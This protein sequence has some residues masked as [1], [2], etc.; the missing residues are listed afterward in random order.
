MYQ[1]HGNSHLGNSTSADRRTHAKPPQISR[2]EVKQDIS[3]EEWYSFEEEWKRFKRITDL[4]TS[5]I[6]DQL[7][8]CCERPL[9]R[10]ILKENPKI[11]DEGEDALL[12]AIQKM[13]VLQVA[14]SVRRTKLL[15][16]KQEL[17]QIFREFY[18]NARAAASTC[19]FKISCPKACCADE[20]PIDYTSKV[21]K[22]ILIAGIADPEIRKDVLGH[23]D[24]D[25][26]ADKDI[27]R[28]VEEKE[29]AK[30][31]V[32]STERSDLNAMS[33]YRKNN[34]DNKNNDNKNNDN[35]NNDVKKKL[36]MKGKCGKC[37][38]EMNLYIQ[39]KSSGKFNKEPFKH[40]MKCHKAEQN[41]ENSSINFIDSMSSFDRD[42]ADT[43]PW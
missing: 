30:N 37:S 29:M 9:S 38:E 34:R 40:C 24:L 42:R 22:D 36:G 35:R 33:T 25:K 17:G 12:E 15:A 27:V 32:S 5:E 19:D 23:P 26:L 2:P 31:A 18:A 11:T 43:N 20:L 39:F 10:L 28:V 16:T 8:Q 4:H 7:L 14:T 3:A 1:S 21:V 6:P 41:K 13:E